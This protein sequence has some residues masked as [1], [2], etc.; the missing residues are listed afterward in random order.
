MNVVSMQSNEI[1]GKDV[2]LH[3]HACD[4]SCLSNATLQHEICLKYILLEI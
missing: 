3:M 4:N 2:T 1:L